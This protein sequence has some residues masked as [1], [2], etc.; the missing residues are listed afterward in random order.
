MSVRDLARKAGR[1][2]W[3]TPRARRATLALVALAIVL[4][5]A[6]RAASART[7]PAYV[8]ERRPLVQRVVASG[9]VMPAARVT[10]GSLSL[11]R[12]V[13]VR[14][15]EGDAVRAGQLLLRLDDA[16]ARAALAQARARVQES[17]ARLDVVRGV[18]SRTAAESVRRAEVRSAQAERDLERVRQLFDGGSASA[19]QLEEAQR[20]LVL[21]RSE[22]E[23]A[24]AQAA[25]V[26]DAG[27]DQRLAAAALRQAQAA[28][29]VAQAK[30]DEKELR[31]P[32]DARVLVRGAEPGDVVQ[33]GAALVVLAEEGRTRLTVQPDEKNLAVL[34]EGQEAEAVADAFP[35]APFR[36]TVSYIAPAVDAARGTIEVRLAVASPPP[37]L[38]PDMT[39]S[40]NVTVGRK[41]D[42][43]V[44]PAEAVRDVGT[45]PWVVRV[46]GGRATRAAVKLGLRGEGMLEVLEGL[47]QG[48]AVV[49]PAAGVIDA[50]TR[51]RVRRLDP[52][53]EFARA[54]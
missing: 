26:A 2:A 53:P 18:T 49:A 7:V 4:G 23:T 47:S 40:V 41:D 19:A 14:V 46:E 33:P 15:R 45:D 9:R 5:V 36:A 20:A 22:A 34:R 31:A 6:G 10:L 1:A 52:P 24:T 3:G 51:V 21:A 30:L 28:V 42:A 44:V 39:V 27:A 17:A 54:L 25:S 29:A 16:E 13:E 11:A 48:D 32:A 12:V 35:A 38:R 50:G 37:F 43:L 8:A